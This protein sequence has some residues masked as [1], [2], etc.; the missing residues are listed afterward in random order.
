MESSRDP[1]PPGEPLAQGE[2]ERPEEAARLALRAGKLEEAVAL[3]ELALEGGKSGD[4]LAP[5]RTAAALAVLG[6]AALRRERP[7]EALPHLEESHHLLPRS[8]TASLIVR[9]LYRAGEWEEGVARCRGF[10]GAYPGDLYLRQLVA[11]YHFHQEDYPAAEEALREILA[12]H[13]DCAPAQALLIDARTRAAP[14][15]DR[16]K[17]LE[18]LFRVESRRKDPQLR[19]QQGRNRLQ[20]GDAEGAC[21]E[22]AEAVALEPENRFYRCQLAFALKRAGRNLEALRALRELFLEDPGHVYVRSALQSVCRASGDLEALRGILREAIQRHP[23]QRFLYGLLKKAQG[24]PPPSS[25]R[26]RT[27]RAP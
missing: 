27:G 16:V 8:F 7:R 17:E 19:Y 11:R 12:E 1:R 10:L 6:E 21:R 4:G 2:T 13:P 24:L 15:A 23:Q 22:F 18:A 5:G 14:P 25:P 26:E 9:S 3:A 20:A